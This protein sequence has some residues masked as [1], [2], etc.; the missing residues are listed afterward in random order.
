MFRTEK[1]RQDNVF[2]IL[3]SNGR[4]DKI[5]AAFVYVSAI[6]ECR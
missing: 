1:R 5:I 6:L 4:C 2:A 3:F